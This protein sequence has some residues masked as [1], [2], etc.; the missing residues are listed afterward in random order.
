MAL[1]ISFFVFFLPHYIFHD[2][3]CQCASFWIVALWWKILFY[4][5]KEWPWIV[6]N[7]HSQVQ[8]EKNNYNY[9]SKWHYGWV[10]VL[11][12][13]AV[14]LITVFIVYSWH[15]IVTVFQYC[16]HLFHRY[17]PVCSVFWVGSAFS[18]CFFYSTM[19][20]LVFIKFTVRSLF[21]FKIKKIN[22][23]SSNR[24]FTPSQVSII[25]STKCYWIILS[26]RVPINLW[27]NKLLP[28]S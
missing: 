16:S 1:F 4:G 19:L 27:F 13:G 28:N 21:F 15:Y 6:V 26:M 14:Y 5:W 11:T 9:N 23:M 17:L 7:G 3:L 18:I 10:T 20:W 2:S 12:V 22:H 25:L 24:S 8:L